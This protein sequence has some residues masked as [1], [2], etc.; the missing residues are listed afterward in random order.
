M[1]TQNLYEKICLKMNT[2][3]LFVKR[4][5]FSEKKE[6]AYRLHT[7]TW[8]CKE[9]FK[10]LEDLGYHHYS[11]FFLT[12]IFLSILNKNTFIEFEK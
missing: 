6:S 5:T 8:I 4:A 3:M 11:A 12:K 9:F 2:E 7:F 10:G 1:V